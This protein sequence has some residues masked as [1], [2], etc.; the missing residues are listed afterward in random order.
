MRIEA[1]Q[2]I[3]GLPAVQARRLMRMI[4]GFLMTPAR[5]SEILGCTAAESRRLLRDL[6]KE[7]YISPNEGE[8]WEVTVKGKALASA[9]AAKPLR[10]ATVERLVSELLGRVGEVNRDGQ[11]A[12]KVETVVVFGSVVI[13]KLRPSDVDVACSLRPRW[14]DSQRQNL[15]EQER[16][17]LRPSRFAS[18]IEWVYWPEFEVL[19]FL[20]S[21][22]RG[23]SIHLFDEWIRENTTYEFLYDERRARS[24]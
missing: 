2:K 3:A 8:S 20:K 14:H 10:R 12:Y 24:E 1:S 5:A 17:E 7:G 21:R 13:Q 16:R 19:R 4:G 23:L 9:T 11:W 15:H 6:G 18:T 22:S